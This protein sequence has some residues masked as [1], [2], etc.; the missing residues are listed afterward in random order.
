MSLFEYIAG[1]HAEVFYFIAGLGLI[2]EL[3]ITGLSG[4]LLFVAFAS[5]ITGLL[6]DLGIISGWETEILALGI[7]SAAITLLLWKPFKNFQNSSDGSDSSS[8]MIGRQVPA[9]AEITATSGSIRYSGI[10]WSSRLAED[11]SDPIAEGA[12]CIII[13]VDG[14]IMIVEPVD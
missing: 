7:L 12:S 14:N 6:I 2:I 8:D 4:P 3:T 1:H 5:L 10:N 11:L 9:S 13:A